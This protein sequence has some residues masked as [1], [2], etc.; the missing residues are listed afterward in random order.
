M[1]VVPEFLIASPAP[2]GRREPKRAT[3]D[4]ELTR[5]ERDAAGEVDVVVRT[6]GA[7][8]AQDSRGAAWTGPYRRSRSPRRLRG[9]KFPMALCV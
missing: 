1:N 7:H 4:G 6:Y 9:R 2:V 3:R 8:C 5:G